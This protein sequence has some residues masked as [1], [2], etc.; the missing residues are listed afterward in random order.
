[1]RGVH[2]ESMLK[3][4]LP[5]TQATVTSCSNYKS[6]LPYWS[7]YCHP[8][9]H[10]SSKHTPFPHYQTLSPHHTGLT[11]C[12]P[13]ASATSVPT[14][15]RP[16]PSQSGRLS[17]RFIAHTKLTPT[18]ESSHQLFLLQVRLFP[19]LHSWLLPLFQI[20]APLSVTMPSLKSCVTI[21][22]SLAFCLPLQV[23]CLVYS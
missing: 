9:T 20:S 22:V 8:H 17:L 16:L 13:P 3:A 15:S 1:M 2:P 21:I 11:R 7:P 19:A 10:P 14:P 4:L 5:L 12:G 6:S 18:L 23:M